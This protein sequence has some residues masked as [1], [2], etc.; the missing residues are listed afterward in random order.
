VLAVVVLAAITAG[1]SQARYFVHGRTLAASGVTITAKQHEGQKSDLTYTSGN[2][3][4]YKEG[5]TINFRF[6]LAA[7]DADSSANMQVRFTGDDGTCL[8]FADYFVLGSIDNV[9]GSSPAISLGPRTQDSFGTSNGEWV[10]ELDINF[11]AAGEAIVNYQLKLSPH[12]GECNGSSQHSRLQPGTDVSQTGQQNVPVPANQVI[13][14]PSIT[15]VKEVDRGTGTFVPASAGEYCFTVDGGASACTD[16]NGQVV[17]DSTLQLAD[18]SHTITESTEAGFGFDHG[19]GTNCTFSGSTAT[20][21][22]AAGTTPTDATCTFFNKLLPAPT[23]TVTKQCPNG[24]ANTGDQFQITNN[25]G[26]V[27]SPL[28]CGHS[29]VVNVTPGQSYSIDEAGANG[30]DLANYNEAKSATGCSG[31]LINGQTASCT[32]TNTLKAQPAVTVTKACPNGAAASTDRF[33]LTNNGGNVGSPL[34]CGDQTTVQLA[35]GASFSFDEAAA[36]TTDLAN[37]VKSIGQNC[38]G[39]LAH[40]G[41]TANC[42]ITNTLKAQPVV[43]VIKSCPN[44]AANAGDL[45]QVTNN[46]TGAGSPIGCDGHVNVQVGAGVAYSIDEAAAGTTDLANYTKSLGDH[47]SGTL[48]HYGDTTSCTITNTL[49][50]APTVTVTKKCTNGAPANSGDRFQI[51]NNGS[52]VADPLACG[53][54]VAVHV[55]AGVAYSIDEAAAGTTD[56]ANYTKSIGDHCSGTLAHFGDTASCTITNELK[57]P[58]KVTVTKSCPGGAAHAGDLFQVTLNGGNAGDPIACGHSVDVQVGA[59]VAYSID[60]AAAGTTKLS[61]YVETRDQTCDGTLAHFGDS[62]V[63]TITNTLKGAPVVTVTKAC[64]N[65]APADPSDRFEALVDG[66]STDPKTVLACGDSAQVSLTPDAAYSITE[67]AGNDTTSLDNYNVSYGDGCSSNDGLARGSTD[68]VCTI[69]NELKPAPVVTV[70]K[71]CPNGAAG[72]GDRFQVRLDGQ[73]VG[74]PLACDGH[75]DVPVTPGNAYAVTEGAAGTT[76]LANYDTTLSEGCSGTLAHFG[77]SASCTVTNALKAAPIL[78]VVKHV[79]NDN[80]GAAKASNFTLSV[81]GS[82]PAPA[83]FPGDEE[84]TVVTLLPGAYSVHE[85]AAAGY[86]TTMNEGCTGTLAHYGDKATCTVT[87]NDVA[88]PPPPPPPPPAP[89]PRINMRIIKSA[90]P[91][92]ATVGGDLTYTLKVTNLGPNQANDVHVTDSLP[93]ETTFVSVS[94]DKGTCTGTNAISCSLGQVAV[95]EIITITIVVK[96]TQAGTITNTAVVAGHESEVDPSDNTSS[97]TVVVNGPFTP[98]SACFALTVR[99][100]SLTVGNRTVVHVTV[101]QLGKGMSGVRV[102]IVGKGT[103]KAAVTNSRGVATFVIK[104]SRPGILQVR[105]PTH[106]TCRKQRIGVIG[107]FTPPVTG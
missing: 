14:F 53:D 99:P 38:S 55:P 26:N 7:S 94:T 61:D 78:I 63:C 101:R 34:A 82:S 15:V 5:D 93:S 29:L 24:T 43:T 41:D 50:A 4:Q 21:T 104:S 84:G 74:D 59:G 57:A 64:T 71:R 87:N 27:G 80:G 89:S 70:T 12:A 17:F 47:C 58:P 52:N 51:T 3:T 32:I 42:T 83:S 31:T 2:V 18:G 62:A 85:A 98:P 56:L 106:A 49:N 44:G 97:A 96:P 75:I 66:S 8:F 77:D 11:P 19:T 86:T 67:Q 22:I 23:V 13:E 1:G 25:G 72:A 100:R 76:D 103:R 68:T 91:N 102:V 9:S 16:A 54:S 88:S 81:T 39:S 36:G 28:T 48:A 92:P 90:S 105:V 45:F 79:I 65:G 46:G 73:D 35:P 95:G 69:T 60:E 30:A 6:D 40:F 107:V 37:Y 33:Q 20:A 10:Q